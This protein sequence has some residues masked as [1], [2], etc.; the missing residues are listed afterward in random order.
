M[1]TS[2]TT[3]IAPT[4]KQPKVKGST[5]QLRGKVVRVLS[6]NDTLTLSEIASSLNIDVK[7]ETELETILEQLICDKLVDSAGDSKYRIAE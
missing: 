3:G 4:S 5:R 2:I 6:E 7:K 1:L